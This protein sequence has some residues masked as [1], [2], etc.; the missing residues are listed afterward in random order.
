MPPEPP[1]VTIIGA[2]IVGIATA[3][4]LI[5]RGLQVTVIDRD[6]PGRG[7]SFG[8]AGGI[9]PGSCVPLAMPGVARKAPGWLLDP[10]GPLFVRLAYL[11][12]ALPWLLR[13]MRAGDKASVERIADALRALHGPTVERY[14]TLVAWAGCE[15]LLVE[16]GQLFL[17]ESA[18]EFDGDGFGLALRRSRGIAMEI[19]DQDELRQLEPAV[20]PF[21]EKAVYLP[22]Q[23]QC[24]NPYRLVQMLAAKFVAEGGRIERGRIDRLKTRDGRI[25]HLATDAGDIAVDTVVLAA[26]AWSARLL[27]TAGIHVP[28][29]AERGYHVTVADPAGMPRIQA[30]WSRR[31]FVATPQETGLRFAGTDEF[32][33][34]DAPPDERR[35][36]VLLRHGKRMIPGLGDG[37]STTWMGHRPGTPDSLPVIGRDPRLSNLLHAFG[38]GHTGLMG[39]S[40][41]GHLIGEI[42]AGETPSLDLAP[43]RVERF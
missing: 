13:F 11:P 31:K 36:Q 27:K 23:A 10:E 30:T 25:T 41:T 17:Y 42:T 24:L 43:Y 22:E 8:N 16:R 40:V 21:F 7:C 34:L 32:A 18:Q 33:G 12:R 37:A 3:S 14:R 1:A 15:E 9:C 20:A 38:H 28:L 5:R 35:A 2:G 4:W 19:L 26:G 29:E 6:E 39:A